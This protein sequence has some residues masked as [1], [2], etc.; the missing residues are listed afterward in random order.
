MAMFSDI[1]QTLSTFVTPRKP[2]LSQLYQAPRVSD[3][4]EQRSD[5]ESVSPLTRTKDW[6]EAAAGDQN[7]EVLE[8][9]TLLDN[10]RLSRKRSPP[11]GLVTKRSAKR[12]KSDDG[13][14]PGQED[15]DGDFEGDTLLASTPDP[16][17]QAQ[18]N[19]KTREDRQAMP[20]PPKPTARL[21]DQPYIPSN[22]NTM[23]PTLQNNMAR[24]QS[25]TNESVISEDE[26]FTKR[27]A[28]RREDRS[29]VNP[30]FEYDRAL[31]HAQA[32]ELPDD[33][34]VWA[35][36]EKDLFYRLAMRG[37]E[38]LVPGHWTM[39]FKTLPQ[40]LFSADERD[41]LILPFDVREFRAKHYLRNL[42]GIAANVRDKSLAGLRTEPTIKRTLRQYISWALLDAGVHPVQR[43]KVVP[44]HAMATQRQGEDSQDVVGRME[45][46]LYKLARRYQVI[47]RVRQ[48]VEPHAQS[49]TPPNS[50]DLCSGTV[51]E[52]DDPH[53]PTLIGLM[54]VSSVVAVVTLDSRAKPPDP[55][56]LHNNRTAR[57][58]SSSSS[59]YEEGSIAALRD[60]SGLRF[61]ANFDFSTH[62]G[63]DVWDGLAMAICIMRIRKTMLELCE[64]ADSEGQ[65][66]K[67]GMWEKVWPSKVKGR[68]GSRRR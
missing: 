64:R 24:K 65:A 6:V 15:E 57:R 66:G 63:Y 40:Q 47:H 7:L 36:A 17:Q 38:P 18:A 28:V 60:E 55:I 2:K 61:I 8:G 34:G 29:E 16:K 44:I 52:Y 49:P 23:H 37:F 33:S 1:S 10:A 25:F 5:E 50:K 45:R 42:F 51:S 48:S 59:I 19:N 41:P 46:R 21:D 9:E 58:R 30:Q 53:M 43:P 22:D 12:Q 67:G 35:E 54:I 11:A 14:R 20:P 26:I 56:T 32:Q 13:Y 39:D 62:D 3:L 4:L 68:E 27:T 31:R